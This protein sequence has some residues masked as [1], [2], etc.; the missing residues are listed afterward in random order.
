MSKSTKN[1]SSFIRT[2]NESFLIL[3]H[4]SFPSNSATIA[5]IISLIDNFNF[6][7][8]LSLPIPLNYLITMQSSFFNVRSMLSSS[9]RLDKTISVSC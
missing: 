5:G 4:Q 9:G 6:T 8:C 7:L 1:I 2:K 3:A